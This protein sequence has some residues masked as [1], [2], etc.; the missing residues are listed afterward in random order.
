MMREKMRI[1]ERNETGF[2]EHR[3]EV[4]PSPSW[5]YL[6][7]APTQHTLEMRKLIIKDK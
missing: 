5:P 2:N 4:F 3:D 6:T 1:P 7:K